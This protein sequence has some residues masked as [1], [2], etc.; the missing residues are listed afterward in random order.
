M[1]QCAMVFYRNVLLSPSI[2]LNH[3]FTKWSSSREPTA[4]FQLLE[5]IYSAFDKLAD[6]RKV[7]KIESESLLDVVSFLQM[8]CCGENDSIFVIVHHYR[9]PQPLEI[10]KSHL[11]EHNQTLYLPVSHHVTFLSNSLRSYVAV[12]GVPDEQHDHAV[13]DG[14]DHSYFVLNAERLIWT[15]QTHLYTIFLCT[16]QWQ[17]RMVKFARAIL[18]K[19]RSLKLSLVESLGEDTENLELRIG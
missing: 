2:T 12:T 17:P 15:S 6:R 18:L 13:S 14:G 8:S 7:Y 9:L 5:T 3:R 19:L 11:R 4:V 16:T 1:F 10:G